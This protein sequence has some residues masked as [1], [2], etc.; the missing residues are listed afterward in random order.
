MLREAVRR[1]I[2]G[3]GLGPLDRYFRAVSS[4]SWVG[5]WVRTHPTGHAFAHRF[6]MYEYL[7]SGP[8]GGGPIDYLEFGVYRGDTIRFWADLNRDP[9]SRFWGFDSF[10]GLPE[11]WTGAFRTMPKGTFDT[12]GAVPEI[13]DA[14]VGFVKGWFQHSLPPFLEG[15]APRNRLVVHCDADLYSST[16]FVLCK[17]DPILKP[18]SIVIFDEFNCPE[19]EAR[20]L[21]DYAS[22]FLREYK[23]LCKT[24]EFCDQVAIEFL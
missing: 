20:A 21:V 13:D 15:F 17:L 1:I 19:G 12:G 6:A 18:G 8:L 23:V 22:S 10:E 5:G 14:R 2:V 9:G 11:D 7:A 24:G 3:K 4:H 16:L